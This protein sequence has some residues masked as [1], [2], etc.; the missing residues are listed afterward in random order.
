MSGVALWRTRSSGIS[1]LKSA[2]T[3][4]TSLR[5]R[6]GSNA[7][8]ELQADLEAYKEQLGRFNAEYHARVGVLFVELDRIDLA[9]AE[10]EFRIAQLR[11]EPQIEP[12]ELERQSEA[13]IR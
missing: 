5:S 9:I 11:A 2:N 1:H 13:V 4:G 8:R 6:R 7:L 10:Y 3:L 12:G